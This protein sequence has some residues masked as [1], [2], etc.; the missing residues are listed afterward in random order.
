[1]AQGND[2]SG[3]LESSADALSDS[4]F[5]GDD[6]VLVDRT[7]TVAEAMTSRLPERVLRPALFWK[8]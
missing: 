8:R 4:T 1:M 5:S 2:T 3:R 7:L 6:A